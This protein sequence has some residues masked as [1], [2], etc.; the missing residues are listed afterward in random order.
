MKATVPSEEREVAPN[1]GKISPGT[2]FR[3]SV[4]PLLSLAG[5]Y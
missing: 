4:D 5:R 1:E 2:V 3:E